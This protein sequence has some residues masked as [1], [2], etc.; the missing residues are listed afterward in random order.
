MSEADRQSWEA[1]YATTP[2]GRPP[3]EFLQRC[4]P[5][6]AGGRALDVAAGN[7]RNAVLLARA[8]FEVDA[9]DISP[10]ALAALRE[11][12]EREGLPIR[13]V[14]ADLEHAPLPAGCYDLAVNIRFLQRSLFAPLADCLRRNGHLVFETFLLPQRQTGHPSNPDYLLAPGELQRV[15]AG[16]EIL[17]Y[18]EGLVAGET[19]NAWLARLLARKR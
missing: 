4:L 13:T 10:T 9:I 12:A 8:G 16:M 6:L 19:G 3:S 14:E 15:F 11:I 5:R 1:R 17:E 18:E 7:G 2:A